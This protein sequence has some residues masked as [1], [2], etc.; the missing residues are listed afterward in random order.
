MPSAGSSAQ[1]SQSGGEQLWGRGSTTKGAPPGLLASWP[2]G[3]QA[4][5][6]ITFPEREGTSWGELRDS[7]EVE[8]VAPAKHDGSQAGVSL[9]DAGSGD[10]E[11]QGI[12][13]REG[14]AIHKENTMGAGGRVGHGKGEVHN[15]LLHL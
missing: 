10:C 13:S 15:I 12:Y 1:S 7:G 4:K 11:S 6:K 5:W 3:L 9:C 8:R 2:P 14:E